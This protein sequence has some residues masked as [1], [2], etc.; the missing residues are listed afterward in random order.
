VVM[1]DDSV[2]G[3]KRFV[4][5]VG[6]R[7]APQA[8][9]VRM[10]AAFVLHA[11]RMS[12][13]QAAGSV[14]CDA[15]HRA[16]VGRMLQRPSFREVEINGELRQALLERELLR[17]ESGQGVF[18]FIIDATLCSQQG[19]QTENTYSTG[20]RRRRPRK[21]RRYNQKKT[22]SKTCH[23]FTM[24]LLI[25]PA[26]VRIPFSRP[27][28][29]REYCRQKNLLHHTTAEAA[30]E[31]IRELPLPEAAQVVVLGDTA[32]DAEVVRQA[33]R[34]RDYTWIFPCNPER[35]LAGPSGAR[36]KVRS[37]LKDWSSW[38]KQSI[39]LAPGQGPCAVYRRVSPHRIGPKAKPRTYTVHQ[40]RRDVHSVGEVRLVFSTMNPRLVKG[41]P[42]DVKILMTN[43]LRLSARDVVELYSLRWQ[44]ELFFKELKS[45]FGFHQYQFQKFVCVERWSE[46]ALTAFLYLEWYRLQQ[47]ARRDLSDDEAR[48]W[49]HQRTH[50]LCQAVRLASQQ[51][52]LKFLAD[53]LKTPGG[54]ARL[55]H[56][57]RSSLAPEYR[58][59]L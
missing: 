56:I 19:R 36:R 31:L 18:V 6:L 39:R 29:T 30:A 50:G 44:I 46:L 37:L 23:S 9:V 1:V 15:R 47:L 11:G 13:L 12:S 41:G 5:P 24:G 40:E 52:E 55:K 51:A 26:G 14:R 42:D 17:D 2:P 45:T 59:K 32:Y 10:V 3:L 8:M 58:G 38:P 28:R 22:R 33:C 4:R 7:K 20:N 49:R 25:T 54:I 43:D 16:Q 57:L 53:R 35:V 48:W 21:G 34:D 27:Y